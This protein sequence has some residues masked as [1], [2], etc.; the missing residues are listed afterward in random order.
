MH[1][2]THACVEG[3]RDGSIMALI[4]FIIY[5]FEMYKILK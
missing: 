2:C 3:G 4:D 5:L 1:A